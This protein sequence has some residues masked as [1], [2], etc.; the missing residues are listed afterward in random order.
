MN[1]L[2]CMKKLTLALLFSVLIIVYSSA[3][4]QDTDGKC[5]MEGSSDGESKENTQCGCKI[6]RDSVSSTVKLDSIE[7]N[8]E[9][10]D[11]LS[12]IGNDDSV[13]S[14][15][16]GP[17]TNEMVYIEG[18]TFKMGTDQPVFMADG[19]MP[20]RQIKINSFYLDKH[21]V[22]NHEFEIFVT[23]TNYKTEVSLNF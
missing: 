6:G 9:G 1:C 2:E 7:G 14:K 16:S 12:D 5:T 4:S 20:A 21:E 19:E 17:R 13:N 22:S 10:L 23:A 18:G 3:Q 8:N 15:Y 11:S